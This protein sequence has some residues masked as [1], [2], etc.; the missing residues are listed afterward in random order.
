LS[1]VLRR[2]SSLALPAFARENAPVQF[3]FDF[4]SPFGYFASLRIDALA[5]KHGRQ[6][7]WRPMLLGVSVLKVMGLKP[8]LET[9]LKGDYL[10]R[11]FARYA[12]RHGLELKRR[13]DD[14]M[15]DPRACGRAYYWTLAHQPRHAKPLARTLLHAYWA[16]GLDLATAEAITALA[17]PDGLAADRLREGIA[18]AEAATLLRAAV[19][20]S[21]QLGVFGSPTVRVDGELFWGVDSFP[22]LEDWLATGGW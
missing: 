4:I 9:P 11:E 19:A 6:V 7:E 12:R 2:R 13:P 10:R 14:P 16:D 22:M 1:E 20:E 3:Y 15:M 18:S 5:A 8:L 21:L 17:L